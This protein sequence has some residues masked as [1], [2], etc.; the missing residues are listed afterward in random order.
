M[1]RP[2]LICAALLAPITGTANA[3]TPLSSDRVGVL[4]EKLADRSPQPPIMVFAHRACWWDGRPENSLSAI[5]ECVTMGVDGIE[6]DVVRTRDDQLVVIHDLTVDRTTNGSGRVMDLTLA[7]IASLRLKTGAGGPDAALT[8]EHVP[9]LEEVLRLARPHF[10]VHIHNKERGLDD[11]ITEIVDRLGM[12]E[13]V[14]MWYDSKLDDEEGATNPLSGHVQLIST[15]NECGSPYKPCRS[16]PIN[17]LTGFGKSNPVALNVNFATHEFLKQ[18]ANAPRPPFRIETNT[19]GLDGG[20]LD[21]LQAEWRTQ[22]ALG[23]SLILTNRPRD[24][25]DLLRQNRAAGR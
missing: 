6:I 23:S 25:L 15:I 14:T 2:L 19:L 9:T 22:I 18:V 13:Q 4:V 11:N 17:D 24:L 12:N 7:E 5:Q 3:Q 16:L 20:S 10:I 21:E 1:K 8:E